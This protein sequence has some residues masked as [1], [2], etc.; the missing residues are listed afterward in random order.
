MCTP[1]KSRKSRRD[2]DGLCEPS[3][4]ESH[5]LDSVEDALHSLEARFQS[6]DAYFAVANL[7][8]ATYEELNSCKSETE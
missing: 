6:V 7:S 8:M 5:F 1:R 3:V 4:E 2:W